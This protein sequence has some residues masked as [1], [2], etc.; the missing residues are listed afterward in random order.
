MQSTITEKIAA[1]H[2]H[3]PRIRKMHC[4]PKYL[5]KRMDVFCE[6]DVR[7]EIYLFI[8]LKFLIIR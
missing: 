8:L 5:R 4:S 2:V 7:Q 1:L 6:I 3:F